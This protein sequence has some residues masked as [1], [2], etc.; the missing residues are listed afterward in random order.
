M[1]SNP[2]TCN[3]G[4]VANP[5]SP[6]PRPSPITDWIIFQPSPIHGVGGFARVDIS[7]GTRIIE[8][9]GEKITKKE[10]L[11]RCERHN[12]C[13]FALDDERDLDG[14]APSNPARFLNHSCQPN[15][16]ALLEQGRIWI[17]SLRQIRAGE[18]LTFN[19]GYDLEDYRQYPCSCRAAGCVGY[20]VA[21]EFFDHLR[22]H[23]RT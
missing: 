11:L 7:A 18:E 21:E 6:D 16:E 4:H 19:Y 20:I 8:Y 2:S 14:N 1:D 3:R 9:T 12:E 5:S 10:S 15:C 13:I 23:I 17:M 22:R